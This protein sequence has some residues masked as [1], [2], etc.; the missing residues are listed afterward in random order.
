MIGPVGTPTSNATQPIAAAA[1]VP[2]IGPFTG[3]ESLRNPHKPNVINV[4]ASYYQETEV[5]VERLTRDL[6]G[7][8]STAQMG[9]AVATAI[10]RV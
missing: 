2:F 8:A 5:M 6:G 4:R 10:D 1:G 3:V 7:A 9:D